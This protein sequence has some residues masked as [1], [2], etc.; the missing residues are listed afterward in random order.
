VEN[1]LGGGARSGFQVVQTIH[2]P[3]RVYE[4][5]ANAATRQRAKEIQDRNRSQ[6]LAAFA[7]G[8]CALGYER[9]PSGNGK[10]LLGKWDENWFYEA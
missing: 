3:A 2:V 5:K 6:F 1:H 9:D 8:L 7:G 4:W 10:F